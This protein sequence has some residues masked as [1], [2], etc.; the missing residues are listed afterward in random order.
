MGQKKQYQTRLDPDVADRVDQYAADNDL[1][2]SEAIRR[3]VREGIEASG[4]PTREEIVD[5]LAEIQSTIEGVRRELDDTGD[6]IQRAAQV[7]TVISLVV[8]AV[9]AFVG[10]LLISG[11]S[12]TLPVW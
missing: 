3:L 8:I 4:G 11:I 9:V 5:D 7:G 1:T 10:V 2:K 6:D 12:G